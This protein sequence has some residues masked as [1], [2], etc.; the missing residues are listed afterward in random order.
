MTIEHLAAIIIVGT[1]TF[2]MISWIASVIK[3]ILNENTP[4]PKRKP[5]KEKI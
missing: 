3:I 2:K 5:L 4:Q 1:F